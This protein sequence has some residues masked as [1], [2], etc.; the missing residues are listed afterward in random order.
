MPT[1]CRRA[2]P[3]RSAA[4]WLAL[5]LLAPA[6]FAQGV[7]VGRVVRV[8]DG[9]SVTLQQGPHRVAVRLAAIDAPELGQQQGEAARAALQTC[10]FGRQAVVQVHGPDR[11]GRT[12]GQLEAGGRDCGLVLVEAGLAWHYK[13]YEQE[14]P[15]A[16]RSA[17]AAA[18]RNA[19]RRR[20]GL[21]SEAAPEPPWAW[22]K[23]HPAGGWVR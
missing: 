23:Q 2:G 19:R 13:A 14:Q 15:L 17:Y 11:H 7:L 12:V 9:D 4:L 22:R 18:E 1:S 20:L 10:A 6:A 16:D 3:R 5:V 21:W 8:H